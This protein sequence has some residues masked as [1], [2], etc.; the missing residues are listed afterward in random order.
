MMRQ[1]IASLLVA[2]AVSASAADVTITKPYFRWLFNGFGFQNSEANF[3]RI[4]P[5]DFRDQRVLKTFHELSPSFARVY[6]GFADSTREELDSFA[7]YYDLTFRRARTTLYA[8]PC[9]M[10]ALPDTLDPKAYAEN[11]AKNLGYL[12][13][14]RN[15]RKIRYYCL[16]NELMAGDRWNWFAHEKKWKVYKDYNAALFHAFR[17]HGLDIRLLSTDEAVTRKPEEIPRD[18]VFRDDGQSPAGEVCAVLR[19]PHRGQCAGGNRR[20]GFC[21][22]QHGQPN[23]SQQYA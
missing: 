17:R 23:R 4:M 10:P 20:A 7:D 1:S 3:L 22:Q 18:Q 16:T 5:E 12:V 15:C 11:V 9:A 19:C 21:S 13:K 8:V 14:V 2:A 6:T